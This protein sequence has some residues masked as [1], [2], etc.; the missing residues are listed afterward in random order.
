MLKK[1]VYKVIDAT[2]HGG[3]LMDDTF[4]FLDL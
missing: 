4:S 1:E 3:H 2:I